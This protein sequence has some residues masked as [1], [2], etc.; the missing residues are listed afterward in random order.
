MRIYIAQLVK[1]ILLTVAGVA[2]SIVIGLMRYGGD[3]FNMSS[4]AFSFVSFG[5]SGAFIFAF[6][7]VRGLSETITAAVVVSAMQFVVSTAWITVLNAAVWSFGVNLP[8]IL[9]AFLFERKL[10]PFR[11][12]KFVVVALL[13]GAMFVVLTLLVAWWTAETLLPASVYRQNFVDGL[14]IG[15]GVAIGI[16]A[17]EALIHSFEHH[18]TPLHK[19]V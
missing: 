11:Q 17:G 18:S 7:H 4:I 14:L 15:L 12:F 1:L 9:V 5:L 19:H 13:Y 2:G 16:E 6:Y 3:V 8:L 10:A